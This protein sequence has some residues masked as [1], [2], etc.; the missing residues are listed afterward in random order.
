MHLS[1]QEVVVDKLEDF[2]NILFVAND[3]NNKEASAPPAV[4]SAGVW[5]L[6]LVAPKQVY[7]RLTTKLLQVLKNPALT[8]ISRTDLEITATPEGEL[9]NKDVMKCRSRGWGGGSVTSGGDTIALAAKVSIVA[10]MAVGK[11]VNSLV[12]FFTADDD[13]VLKNVKRESKAYSHKDQMDELELQ[14]ELDA[15]KGIK[16]DMTPK[17]KELLAVELAKEAVIR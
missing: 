13:F 8:E 17:Q 5:T 1:P 3:N 7:P 11:S 10:F 15:K 16:R 6:A 14:R 4:L 12:S 9:Y 2:V